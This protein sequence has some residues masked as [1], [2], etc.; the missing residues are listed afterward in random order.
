MLALEIQEPMAPVVGIAPTNTVEQPAV[1]PDGARGFWVTTNG[2]SAF[3]NFTDAAP[4]NLNSVSVLVN[5]PMYFPFAKKIRTLC[6]AVG[7]S[8]V[9]I[10]WVK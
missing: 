1:P 8:N 5:T 10:Q 4:T 3:L 9:V 7:T 6:T 2:N